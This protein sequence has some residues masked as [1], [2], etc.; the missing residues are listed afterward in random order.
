MAYSVREER[1]SLAT[2]LREDIADA[3]RVLVRLR[4]ENVESFLQLLDRIEDSF[5]QLESSGLDLRPEQTRWGS[6]HSKLRR[7]ASR[8]TRVLDVAGGLERLRTENPPAQ[9]LWWHLDEVV[10]ADRRRFIL[11]LGSTVGSVVVLLATVWALFTFVIPTDPDVIIK[12]EATTTLQQMAFEGRWEDALA[13]IEE[14]KAQLTQSDVE[15]LIWEAVIRD[16][17]GQSASAQDILAAA[18]ALV[19][20]NQQVDY[21]WELGFVLLDIG[22]LEEARA[23]GNEML[24]LDPSNPQGYFLLGTVAELEGDVSAALALFDETFQLALESNYQLAVIARVRMGALLQ[25]PADMSLFGEA[26]PDVGENGE[27][28]DSGSGSE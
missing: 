3:E 1:Q 19:P 28:G 25:R 26:Q 7:E 24:A 23:A 18:K 20:S 27:S 4:R 10:A 15:L 16:K 6:L 22:D 5:T 2:S 21:W 8:V 17:L 13:V 12:S 14:A 9:G 11:R